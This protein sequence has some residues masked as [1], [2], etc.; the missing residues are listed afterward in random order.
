VHPTTSA[1]CIPPRLTKR[2][3]QRR[4][5]GQIRR[6]SNCGIQAHTY[7]KLVHIPQSGELLAHTSHRRSDGIGVLSL[8]DALLKI[9]SELS[10]LAGPASFL[11]YTEVERLPPSIEDVAV[12]PKDLSAV[13]KGRGAAAIST[14][15]HSA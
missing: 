9:A 14:F 4:Y 12:V 11:W 7:A 1:S 10:P 5:R 8:L 15:T 6:R 2:Y 3:H 13:L